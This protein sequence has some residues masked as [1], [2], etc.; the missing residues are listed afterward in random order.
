[1]LQ[2][3]DESNSYRKF[4]LEYRTNGKG[5]ALHRPMYG[6]RTSNSGGQ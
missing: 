5:N 6:L 3:H 4:S 1:M 2:Y